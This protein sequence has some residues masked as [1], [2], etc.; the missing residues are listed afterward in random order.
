MTAVHIVD[1]DSLSDLWEMSFK[2]TANAAIAAPY[3][4]L[5]QV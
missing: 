1:V 2:T 5:F 4:D 3:K